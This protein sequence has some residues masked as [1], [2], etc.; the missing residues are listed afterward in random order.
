MILSITQKQKKGTSNAMVRQIRMVSEN[1]ATSM[2]RPYSLFLD[3]PWN[4]LGGVCNP[5]TQHIILDESIHHRTWTSTR[6]AYFKVRIHCLFVAGARKSRRRFRALAKRVKRGR[7]ARSANEKGKVC[8]ALSS[9]ASHPHPRTCTQLTRTR[10]RTQ[11]APAPDPN[12]LYPNPFPL[13]SA[14]SAQEI[15][16]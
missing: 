13:S 3:T 9:R 8:S 5:D 16:K 10:T 6:G 15:N 7:I 11:P 12:P 4:Q 14:F 2:N 1:L